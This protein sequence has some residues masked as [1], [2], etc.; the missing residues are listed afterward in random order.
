VGPWDHDWAWGLPLIVLNVVIH[1]CGLGVIYDRSTR[2]DSV[3]SGGR[4]R[5][6]S[7]FLA[8]L[9]GIVLL[10]TMLHTIEATTWAM[11]F[12]FLG[13]MPDNASAMLYSLSAMTSYG[14]V[15]LFL[16]GRWQLMGALEALN[17]MML[18][19]LT[20]AFL[21]ATFQRIW[22]RGGKPR[23]RLL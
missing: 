12:R 3:S 13:A 18:F 4:R 8:R 23:A 11:A 16:T 5:A 9:V 1:V 6:L 17:G 21:F 15:G 2:L 22:P 14:H 19:G 10:A 20:T 7:L